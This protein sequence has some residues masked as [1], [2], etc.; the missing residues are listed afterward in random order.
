M[1]VYK[2]SR[3]FPPNF[4]KMYAQNDGVSK[5]YPFKYRSFGYLKSRGVKIPD[6]KGSNCEASWNPWCRCCRGY[7][8]PG[9]VLFETA[10]FHE[11]Q[12]KTIKR[13][14]WT[15]YK[16]VSLKTSIAIENPRFS[17]FLVHLQKRPMFATAMVAY[18]KV[19][20][21]FRISYNPV[22]DIPPLKFSSPLKSYRNPIGKGRLP[23]TIFRGLC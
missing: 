15:M 14:P 17:F 12:I 3:K 22:V 18:L 16:H 11:L 4:F 10:N 5:I 20:R 9:G 13:N 1:F 23:I 2:K 6:K 8:N 21:E 7:V 19:I